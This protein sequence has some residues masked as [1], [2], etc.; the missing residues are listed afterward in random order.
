LIRTETRVEPIPNPSDGTV[1]IKYT[2]KE[3]SADQVELSAGWGG[4]ARWSYR[5]FRLE[6]QQLLFKKYLQ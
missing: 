2:V 6:V 4:K 1:D 3:K 5:Y